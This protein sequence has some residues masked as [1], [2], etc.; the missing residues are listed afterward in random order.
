[1]KLYIEIFIYDF[2]NFLKK[3]IKEI[4]TYQKYFLIKILSKH[5]K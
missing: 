5:V 1:M 4:S 2:Q 3:R